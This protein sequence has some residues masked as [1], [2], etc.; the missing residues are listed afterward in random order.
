MTATRRGEKPNPLRFRHPSI[1]DLDLAVQASR[2][3]N[4]EAAC[5]CC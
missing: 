2:Q 4:A 1:D 3:M 5:S